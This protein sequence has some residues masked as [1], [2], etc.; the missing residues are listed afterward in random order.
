MSIAVKLLSGLPAYGP[1][2]H[3]RIRVSNLVAHSAAVDNYG[4]QV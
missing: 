2:T 1:F 3:T 4:A